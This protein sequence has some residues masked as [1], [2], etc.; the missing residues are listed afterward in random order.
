MLE[1][2]TTHTRFE[3]NA[4]NWQ[5]PSMKKDKIRKLLE[6]ALTLTMLPTL[7]FCLSGCI[8]RPSKTQSLTNPSSLHAVV[9]A[10]KKTGSYYCDGSYMYGRAEGVFMKQVDA[11]DTGYQP[12]LGA[13]CKG[14]KRQGSVRHHASQPEYAGGIGAGDQR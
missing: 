11:L 2:G 12:A 5:G 10:S 14:S 3:E 13:Y 8:K 7:A 1:G 6:T 9:W 4:Q